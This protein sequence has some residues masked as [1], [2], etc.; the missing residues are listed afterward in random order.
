[1]MSLSSPF[2]TTD[3]TAENFPTGQVDFCF[4]DDK[5]TTNSNEYDVNCFLMV[6][7]FPVIAL[8]YSSL[9]SGVFIGVGGSTLHVCAFVR[10][11]GFTLKIPRTYKFLSSKANKDNIFDAIEKGSRFNQ[12]FVGCKCVLIAGSPTIVKWE[13][14]KAKVRFFKSLE[15]FNAFLVLSKKSTGEGGL[16]RGKGIN[17]GAIIIEAIRDY[18]KDMKYPF[19]VVMGN[20]NSKDYYVTVCHKSNEEDLGSGAVRKMLNDENIPNPGVTYFVTSG[21]TIEDRKDAVVKLSKK[22][23]SAKFK[24]LSTYAEMNMTL[25]TARANKVLSHAGF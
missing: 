13:D 2:A 5:I 3:A 19:M 7:V 6:C 21:P 24:V 12:W 22:Y 17:H 9:R 20:R 1:M 11:F 16:Y 18:L 23:P 25:M 10:I 14:D 4:I 8:I 15:D